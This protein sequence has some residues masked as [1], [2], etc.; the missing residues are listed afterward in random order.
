M[1]HLTLIAS[2]VC[3]AIVLATT[4][5]AQQPASPPPPP[6][7]YGP[8]ITTDQA[9]KAIAAA[10]AEAQKTPYLYAFAIVDPSGSLVYFEKMDG[11]IYAATEIA[12]RKARTA[13]I[14]KRPTKAFFDQMESGHPYVATLSP[15]LT[16]SIGGLPLVVDGKVIGGIGVSGSPTGPTDLA[17]AQAGADA[18]K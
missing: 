10:L 8:A 15:E 5:F 18:L 14:F 7:A 13:A 11:A 17:P 9:K 16:A 2:A 4:A 12:V 3:A 1:R 6:P